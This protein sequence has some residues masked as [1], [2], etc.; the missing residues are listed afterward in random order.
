MIRSMTGYGDAEADS[1]AGRIR[2]EIRTV[3]HRYFS[4]NL[5]LSSV[6]ERYEPQV[7]EWL[8]GHFPRGHV[9]FS[10]RLEGAASADGE[11]PLM[12][13]EVRA[14]NYVQLLR[15]LQQKFDLP[16]EVDLALVTRMG[17]LFRTTE[18]GATVAI[19]PDALRVVV[20]AAAR[21]AIAMREDEGRRLERDL[22]ERL[23][24]MERAIA[25]I[26][27]RAPERLVYERDRLRKAISELAGDVAIDDERIAREIAFM[28]ERWDISEE[29]VRLG[30][31]IELFR[32]T[33]AASAEEPVGKRLGFLTQEMHRETNTIGSKA[34]DAVIEHRVIAIKEE[35]ER[36]REQI[37]NIE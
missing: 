33:L 19:E 5:K 24:A 15:S 13:D 10:L 16:G 30:S 35:L 28:A 36:L 29:L 14:A 21:A 6:F 9:N 7:R 34:N 11:A 20:D 25:V 3:N 27:E 26:A 2:A 22:E 8:R 4:A 37:E 12:L 1:P 31:H 18:E 17:D 23:Q 32:E